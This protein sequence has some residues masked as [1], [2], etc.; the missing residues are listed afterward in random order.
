MGVKAIP[1]GYHSVTPY[2][3]VADATAFIEF[4]KQAFGAKERG[5]HLGPAGM[6]MHA[7]VQIGDSVV[8]LSDESEQFPAA[9]MIINLYVEDVDGAYKRAMQAG[10]ESQREP[11]DQPY[12]DRSAGVKDRWGNQW[13]LAT[14]IEDVSPEEIERRMRAGTPAG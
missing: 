14:H 8:M 4:L 1:D 5:R 11:G 10:G 3:I 13:W 6:I 7:E 2:F 9:T 12:G